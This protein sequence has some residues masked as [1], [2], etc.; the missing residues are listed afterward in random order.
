MPHNFLQELRLHTGTNGQRGKSVAAVVWSHIHGPDF[1]HQIPKISLC[2]V[3]CSFIACISIN[4][5]LGTLFFG[6]LEQL[7]IRRLPDGADR[8][9]RLRPASVLDPEIK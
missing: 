1:A 8:N 2:K 3:G 9:I 5:A 4:Q 7:C 6:A